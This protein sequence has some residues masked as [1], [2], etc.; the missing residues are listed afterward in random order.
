MALTENYN[1][2]SLSSLLNPH[3]H[4]HSHHCALHK[5]MGSNHLQSVTNENLIKH[6]FIFYGLGYITLLHTW[7]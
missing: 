5:H 4:E 6:M 7:A 2:L 1:N 3:A